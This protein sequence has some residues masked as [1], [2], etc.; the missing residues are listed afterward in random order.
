MKEFPDKLWYSPEEVAR[1]FDNISADTIRELCR[2]NKI[3]GA[4]KIGRKWFIPRE[5][6]IG[7]SHGRTDTEEKT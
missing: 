6:I 3:P 5:Y 7:E 4:R 1:I 2:T